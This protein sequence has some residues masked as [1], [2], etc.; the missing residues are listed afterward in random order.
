VSSQVDVF[1][2]DILPVLRGLN[3]QEITREK[4]K[5][6]AFVVLEKNRSPK[7]VQNIIRCLSSLLSHAVEDGVVQVNVALKPGKFLPNV[8][9]RRGINPLTREGVARFLEATKRHDPHHFPL[10]LC[11][12]RTGMRLGEILALQWGDIDYHGRFILVQYNYTRGKLSTPKSGEIR[13]VDM[14]RE[15]TQ[16][17]KALY[18]ERQLEASANGWRDVLIWVFCS[19]TGGC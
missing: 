19:E 1:K 5:A 9:K 6:L 16:A 11:A 13:R 4:V 14:S 17:F 8:S 7:T 18:V 15:L 10:F 12:V 2:G 3:L